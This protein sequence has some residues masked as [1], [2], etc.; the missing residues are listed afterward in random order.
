MLS[1]V[2]TWCWGP[3]LLRQEGSGFESHLLQKDIITSWWILGVP[4]LI[5]FLLVTAT[6]GWSNVQHYVYSLDGF[7]IVWDPKVL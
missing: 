4:F 5:S 2:G 6:A 1:Q 7:S 3:P